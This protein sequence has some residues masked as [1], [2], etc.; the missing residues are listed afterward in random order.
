MRSTRAHLITVIA[1]VLTV[2]MM[3]STYPT[4]V[5][6]ATADGTTARQVGTAPAAPQGQPDLYVKSISLL[7]AHPNYYRIEVANKGLG[8]S[9]ATKLVIKEHDENQFGQFYPSSK[10]VVVH[11]V[12]ERAVEVE[13]ES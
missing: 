2:S 3:A 5:A 13:Q 10:H 9:P 12:D 6:V 8:P 7:S 4:Q 1:T 11:R